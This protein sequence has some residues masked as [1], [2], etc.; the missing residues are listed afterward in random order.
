MI[1]KPAEQTPLTACFAIE[2]LHQAGIP[3]AAVQ[4][5]PG[6]GE[7]VGAALTAD[8]RVRGVVFTG[9]TEVARRINKSMAAREGVRLIAETGGQN[10]MIVDSSALPEQVVQDVLISGFDSAG[11]RC[12]ALRVLCL[13]HDIAEP[14]LATL[15]AA[16]GELCIGNPARIATDIGPIID[17]DAR[18][19]LITHIEHMCAQGN[20]VFQLPLPS[21][22]TSGCFAAPTLIEIDSLA[23][24]QREVFGPVVHVLR[25]DGVYVDNLIDAINA[26]GYGLTLGVHSRIDETVQRVA[27][28]AR[29]GNI[30]VNRSMV[31]AVVGVQPFGGEGL[32]GTGPKAGGPLY[33]HR[34]A[35]SEHVRPSVL[36][37]R[38]GGTMPDVSS[39]L[40]RLGQWARACGCSDLAR[41]CAEYAELTPLS[42]RLDLPG[43]TGERNTLSF[44]ARGRL[45]C[46]ASNENELLGQIAA[47][48]AVDGR[49][50]TPVN[51][52]SEAVL[53][54]LPEELA[55]GI[56]SQAQADY[57]R[58]GGVL[59][60]GNA[61]FATSLH[62]RLADEPGPLVP[63][64]QPGRKTGLYPLFR[65]I[66]ERVVSVNTAAAGG[67]TSLMALGDGTG[68]R[69]ASHESA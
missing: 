43:P 26:T 2:L 46:L 55:S 53:R 17:E 62:Q 36:G 13:Q 33:V 49:V 60:A 45:L 14:V 11:Q 69:L 23:D 58:L 47:V 29:V 50:V 18:V 22:C 54:K 52:T 30:Y 68:S 25:F 48:F 21:E 37:W 7:T 40:H 24:L 1:A 39:R 57:A 34:L 20:A 67:N 61:G 15:K 19:R 9:S 65:M 16:M 5:L 42:I 28:R 27:S 66:I 12:S 64:F 44:F 8:P 31:G 32:S 51:A 4:L 41:V 35:A 38:A 56:E 63:L 3:L 6:R 10:A 59:I